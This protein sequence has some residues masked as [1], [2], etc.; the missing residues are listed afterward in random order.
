M[1]ELIA[2]DIDAEGAWAREGASHVWH[3]DVAGQRKRLA[4][5]TEPMDEAGRFFLWYELQ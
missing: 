3:R 5:G 1:M 4:F 2:A